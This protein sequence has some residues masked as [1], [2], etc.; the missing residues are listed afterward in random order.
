M[1]AAQ[2]ERALVLMVLCG[3][4]CAA[5][6]DGMMILRA[7]MRPGRAVCAALDLAYG[8]VPA[9][10]MTAAGLMLGKSPFR[11]YM[12]AGT[13][14]GMLLWFGTLGRAGRWL[15]GLWGRKARK[16]SQNVRKGS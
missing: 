2:Q 15:C 8:A 13:A 7:L 9:A 16:N 11:L 12:F 5:L 4:C 3:V 1:G 14:L 10:G 6:Y